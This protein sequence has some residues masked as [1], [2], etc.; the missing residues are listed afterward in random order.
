MACINRELKAIY[1]HLPK[2][3]G[4]YIENILISFYNFKQVRFGR[5]DHDDFNENKNKKKFSEITVKEESILQLRNKGL[6][7][8]FNSAESPITKEEWNTYYKFT[9]VR[10]PYDRIVS[11]FKY[12][13]KINKLNM[14]INNFKDF[15]SED[16]LLSISDYGYFHTFISQYDNLI[17]NDT[18]NTNNINI[19]YI[20]KFENLNND[21]ITVLHNI[22]ISEIKHTKYLEDNIIINSSNQNKSLYD[23][24]DKTDKKE[25]IYTDYYDE[26]CL[27]RI[28]NYFEKDF[29]NF[30][31]KICK[32]MEE[33]IEDSKKYVITNEKFIEKNKKILEEIEKKNQSKNQSK[34]IKVLTEQE[35]LELIYSNQS[36]QSN[37]KF[38]NFMTN[39]TQNIKPL[40][41]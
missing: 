16:H 3:G 28:N 38:H 34:N 36:N 6:A 30:N 29:E 8:Y 24:T 14:D 32:N 37:K 39:L 22:G 23:K 33:L 9:F 1:I 35:S 18:N 13:N 27:Q 12:L 17:D 15:I 41:T 5:L 10:N 31:F 20:G 21:F 40:D 11:A 4:L 25:K 19:N 2:V 7:R 26:G